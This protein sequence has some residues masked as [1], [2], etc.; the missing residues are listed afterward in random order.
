[1]KTAQDKKQNKQNKNTLY[2]S[3]SLLKRFRMESGE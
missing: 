1:M 2:P 3:L